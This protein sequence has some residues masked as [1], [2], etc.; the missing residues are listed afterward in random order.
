MV[1]TDEGDFRIVKTDASET[2]RQV[3]FEAASELLD[4]SE[5]PRQQIIV[6]MSMATLR[7]DDKLLI[8]YKTATATTVDYGLSTVRVPI[9]R[10]NVRT[11][12]VADS[13]LRHSNFASADTTVA[14]N[15]WVKIGSYTIPAQ[16]ELRIGQ[17]IAENSRIYV[18]L[19][20]NA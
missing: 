5:D 2:V 16:E 13:Y 6:P 1:D 12:N 11:G 9:R 15:T 20:E 8:E 18:A 7:E 4:I 3:L 14:A 10:R 17:A 19:V